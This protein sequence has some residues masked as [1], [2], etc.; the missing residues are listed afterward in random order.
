MLRPYH[1]YAPVVTR[2]YKTR[3]YV[4][5]QNF[6]HMRQFNLVTPWAQYNYRFTGTFSDHIYYSG[7]T[8]CVTFVPTC[9]Q[10]CCCTALELN[11]QCSHLLLAY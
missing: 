4:F 10:C 7:R 11:N 1:L 5:E 2:E 8:T 6:Q 9:N 3:G